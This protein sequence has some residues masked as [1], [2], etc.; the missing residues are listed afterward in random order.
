MT[1]AV[2]AACTAP[3]VPVLEVCFDCG[4][5]EAPTE[6]RTLRRYRIAPGRDRTRLL[7]GLSALNPEAVADPLPWIVEGDKF[8]LLADVTPA[9]E[10]TIFALAHASTAS[11]T[12]VTAPSASPRSARFAWDH[13]IP[14]K[15]GTC[16]ALGGSALWLGIPLVPFAS[17]LM[18]VLLA[19]RA[20]RWV[21]RE[22]NV[23][24]AR[25]NALLG[26][27]DGQFVADLRAARSRMTEPEV[28]EI[29]QTLVGHV[30][31][32]SQR[33]RDGA[34][35]LW[36]P[37]FSR[38]DAALSDF[39]RSALRLALAANRAGPQSD[40]PED[41]TGRRYSRSIRRYEDATRNLRSIDADLLGMRDLVAA[42]RP[43]DGDSAALSTAHRTLLKLKDDCT[44]A[45]GAVAV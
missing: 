1:D 22:V 8:D 10:S 42:T 17:S 4:L 20:T 6:A 26:P 35:H 12:P 28:V 31:E 32:I 16:A 2:C 40:P 21:A 18:L 41:P 37:T 15:M 24:P 14:V 43:E 9:Q 23:L 27:V 19:A 45:L 39:A 36:M 29:V 33:L 38:A 44:S 7:R 11:V 25:A 34:A 13:G 3:L 5:R 30:A